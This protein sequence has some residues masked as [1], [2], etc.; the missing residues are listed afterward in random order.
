MYKLNCVIAVAALL[1]NSLA[2]AATATDS[3]LEVTKDDLEGRLPLGTPSAAGFAILGVTPETVIDPETG[4]ELLVELL[5][6]LDKNGNPQSGFALES[7][8]YL[9][10]QDKYIEATPSHSR[11]FWSGFKLSFASADGLSDK[12][13]TKRYGL[14]LN[15]TY[16]FDDPLFNKELTDCVSKVGHDDIPPVP[17]KDEERPALQAKLSKD[18]SLCFKSNPY[19]WNVSTIAAGIAGHRSKNDQLEPV[20]GS[21]AWVTGSKGWGSSYQLI[22]HIRYTKD[23][24]LADKAGIHSVDSTV[25]G[26]RFRGGSDKLRG[27]LEAAYTN[28]DVDK[29]N[30]KYWQGL[31]GLEVRMSE[32]VW[33]QVAIGDTF[34]ADNKK[35]FFTGK[36]RYGF[37]DKPVASY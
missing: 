5:Q 14:G 27:L 3:K 6:G 10:F 22:G 30:D 31:V 12:D 32:A 15:W 20:D 4:R 17:P 23:L 1:T 16:N 25:F 9:W 24:L 34:G 29:K 11:R 28:E 19:K 33:I 21:S 2:I 35:E 8:P 36:L 37:S 18:V 26:A 13:Q 7:R